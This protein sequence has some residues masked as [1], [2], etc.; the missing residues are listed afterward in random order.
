[1]A[2]HWKIKNLS[3]SFV[4][5]LLLFCT[6]ISFASGSGI[7][8]NGRLLDPNGNAV[9]SSNVQF[10]L[11]IRTPGNENCLMYEEIQTKDMTNSDGI[12]SITI[13]DGTGARTDSSGFTLD[14]IFAN[15]GSFSFPGGYCVTGFNYSP[16]STDGR[17]LQVYFN[18]GSFATGQWEP[19]PAM[20]INFI[21]MAIEAQ[22]VGGYKKEQI[23]KL[24]DG[25]STTGSE[26]DATKWTSLQALINGTSS[27]YVKPSDQVTQLY[28]ASIPTPS[29]GQSIRWNSSLNAGAGGWENFTAG[30]GGGSVTTVSS[31]NADIGVTNGST[32][33][34]LTLNSGTGAN[35]IVKLNASSQLPAVDGANLTNVNASKVGGTT[36]SLAALTNGQVLK[37]N[38][39]NWVNAS[40]TDNDTL[41][42]LS[43]ANGRVAYYSGSAWGCLEVTS[44]NTINTIVSR[45]GSGESIFGSVNTGTLK[46]ND[47]ATGVVSLST[48]V[49]VASYAM[50]LPT[51][52]GT[53]GQVLTTD[54]NSPAQLSWA[55]ASSQ[56]TTSGSNIYYN[57]GNV[58][59]GTASPSSTLYV[60]GNSVPNVT[61]PNVLSVIG[62]DSPG[63][64]GVGAGITLRSGA[65]WD[66]PGALLTM[67]GG[68]WGSG[69]NITIQ[70]GANNAGAA[71][72]AVTILGGGAGFSSSAGAV[73][74]AG[75]SG[76]GAG[77][78]GSVNI[79][80]GNGGSSNVKGADVII[81]GGV[82]GGTAVDGNVLL[83]TSRGNVGIKMT[84]PQA[85]LDV[86]GQIVS[87]SFDNG[88]AV[89]FDMSN[90][91][92]QYTSASCGAMTMSNL[93][94]GGSYTLVVQGATSGT[95]TFTAT[96]Y[97]FRFNPAN[98]PT[99][100]STHTIY[101]MQV[102]GSIVY[103]SWITGF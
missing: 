16:N 70:A 43:C 44:G 29:N 100:A 22:Q 48:P 17:K 4:I 79:T 76:A 88:S 102:I 74:I 13:N 71:A 99:T 61:M 53:A 72:G 20:A 60:T 12:F 28:G 40:L 63:G 2:R 78:G 3:V 55:S 36:V 94:D 67:T 42:G 82:K 47:G 81:N 37:Y 62:A 97:T 11:Q 45:D 66:N 27:A 49:T 32:T 46:L 35:Q 93:V 73:N 19:T 25:V 7:T 39:S 8:Y 51:S 26:L 90:G 14:Q 21:P 30:S 68:S 10:R 31:A 87:R 50:R 23:L 101:S 58:G 54:G 69:G 64:S 57:I 1:M 38:G 41:G 6:S 9:N 15:R 98:G 24:A 91:N 86:Q 85:A 34:Q 5:S 96:G 80:G 103:V 95:C 84:S 65:G 83:A 56:W 52:V 75:G 18:D 89:A 33:P 77:F 92:A 59:I